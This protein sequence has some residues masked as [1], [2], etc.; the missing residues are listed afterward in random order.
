[1]AMVAHRGRGLGLPVAKVPKVGFI[2]R[3]QPIPNRLSRISREAR[4]AHD[5]F[6]SVEEKALTK[7]ARA[8]VGQGRE[9]VTAQRLPDRA[10]LSGVRGDVERSTRS[11]RPCGPTSQRRWASQAHAYED[12]QWGPSVSAG[13]G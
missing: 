13:C 8:T 2:P 6:A 3:F 5:G 1:M 9:G 12:G 4:G 7:L 11:N 10:R